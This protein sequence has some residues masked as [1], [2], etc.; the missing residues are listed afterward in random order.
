[1]KLISRDFRRGEKILIAVLALVLLGLAYYWVVDQPVR[2]G[3]E[4]ANAQRDTLQMDLTIA[5]AKLAQLQKMQAELDSIGSLEL[6]SRMGS[7]NNSREELTEL[8]RILSA[9]TSYSISFPDVTRN[10]DQIRRNF[11]LNFTTETYGDA[12]DI[13]KALRDCSLRCALGNITFSTTV[14]RGNA[15]EGWVEPQISI[16]TNATFFETMYDGVPDAGL[17]AA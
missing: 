3:I 2:N 12:K 8:N 4:Q 14:R 10:G 7:Y 5:Q 15:L 16:S 17:P 11:T 6:S 9:A 13:I 1:M